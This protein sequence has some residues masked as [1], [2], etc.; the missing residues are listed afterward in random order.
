MDNFID[1]SPASN[2]FNHM[3]KDSNENLYAMGSRYDGTNN[4][5]IIRRSTDGGASWTQVAQFPQR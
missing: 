3:M 5:L 2:Y 4:Y 1:S